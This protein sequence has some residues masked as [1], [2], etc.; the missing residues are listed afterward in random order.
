[1]ANK[2]IFASKAP[3]RVVP[4][5]NTV[6]AAGGKA[7]KMSPKHALAQIA[8]TN[9]F[10]STYYVSAEDN[11]KVA[12]EAA[13]AL[14]GNPEFL[15]KVAVYSRTKGYMKD[16]PAFL[17][18]LLADISPVHFR[19]VFRKVVNNGK[20]LR[21][22]VQMAR[23][24]AFGRVRGMHT[25]TYRSALNEWFRT[26]NSWQIFKAAIGNDPSM[27]DI[28]RMSHVRPENAEK[29]A[30]YAYLV[31]AKVE[32][33]TLR[34]QG[35]KDAVGNTIIREH[36]WKNLPQVVRDYENY[37]LF[38]EGKVPNVDFRYL[39]SLGLDKAGWTEVARNGG[40]MFTRMNL[41]TFQRHGVF[42]DPK[43]VDLIAARLR[44]KEQIANAGAFPYQLLMAWKAAGANVPS[45]IGDALH[46]A[47]EIAIDNV[48]EIKGKVYIGVDVSGS[49]SNAVTGRRAGATSL[50]RCVDVA[51]LFGCALFRRNKDAELMPFDTSVHR[52]SMNPR[53]TVMT[54]AQTLAHFG[55]GGTNCS[56]VLA[57]LNRRNAKGDAVI[58]VS[59]NESWV[60]SGHYG[61]FGGGATQTMQEWTAFRARNP[62]ARM[63]CIDINP[64][65]NSQ[66]SERKDILQVGGFG[67]QVFSVIGAWLSSKEDDPD[68]WVREI[69]KVSLDD[70]V[71]VEVES[72]E[73]ED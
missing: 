7:Y 60:D 56:L 36:S 68:Y 67:D 57:D 35:P 30:L 65:G 24:G 2:S 37:K 43:M 28:L 49:M 18:V 63:V 22:V 66:A 29:A 42:D 31:G 61:R 26:H 15:A 39:D 44:D 3:S 20:M 21:N 27:R 23:A 58:Y 53:D 12:K 40:W 8:C 41:N 50:V 54:N 9:C 71:S 25:G 11:L 55:G 17:A 10:N 69:E 16:M 1:M 14:K 62:K 19:K 45:K 64:A 5:A 47:M 59:D 4:V 6:N 52:H 13:L 73:D 34:I 38:H 48:P 70:E 32:G 51:A 33:D 72:E 46:E